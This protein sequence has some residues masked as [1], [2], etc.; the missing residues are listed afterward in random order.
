[1]QHF[2]F[3]AQFQDLTRFI[4]TSHDIRCWN[5][6]KSWQVGWYND[7]TVAIDPK[8]GPTTHKLVGVANYD[9]ATDEEYVVIKIESGTD[10]DL[11][12]AFN[13]ATGVN[14]DNVQADDQVTVV[15]TGENGEGFSQSYLK[16]TL[17]Q[18]Q[19]HTIP[20]WAGTG[21]SLT[22]TATDIDQDS[23]VWR[24]TIHVSM[25]PPPPTNAPTGCPGG[26]PLLSLQITADS[27]PTETSFTLRD[28]CT[29]VVEKQE[30]PGFLTT[31]SQVYSMVHCATRA[32]PV[33]E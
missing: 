4:R 27:F 32:N 1:M 8:T 33:F 16:A 24:A 15:E 22:I 9:V 28:D 2:G 11:F 29:N 12:V 26:F 17:L 3:N 14:S 7:R 31:Q 10:T 5:A 25:G 18:G 30:D 6:A 19:S 23:P 20:N 13:R 21:Q